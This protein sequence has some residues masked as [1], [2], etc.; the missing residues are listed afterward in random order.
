[1]YATDKPPQYSIVQL[2]EIM[3]EILYEKHGCNFISKYNKSIK[4]LKLRNGRLNIVGSYS[5][6]NWIKWMQL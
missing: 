6:L 2:E 1:M 5:P 4:K 3:M